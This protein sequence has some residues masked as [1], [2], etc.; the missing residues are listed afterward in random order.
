MTGVCVNALHSDTLQAHLHSQWLA[1]L[2]AVHNSLPLKPFHTCPRATF[3]V[4]V[5]LCLAS[6]FFYPADLCAQTPLPFDELGA[7]PRATAMGQAFTALADDTSAAYYNPAGLAQVQS[8]L[9]ITLGYQYAKPRIRVRFDKEPV[10]NPLLGKTRTNQVEDFSTKALYFGYSCNFGQV[11]AFKGSSIAE[12]IGIGIALFTNLPEVNQFDNPQRPQ[13]PYVFKYNERWSLISLAISCAVTCAPWLS[14]GG[15]V[16]PRVDSLQESTGSW[17]DLSGSA[18]PRDIAKGMRMNLNAT[19]KVNAVPIGGILITLPF[20]N[21]FKDKVSVG[22]SYRGKM[23]GFYGT[24]LTSVD[25][26]LPRPGRDPVV[27]YSDPGMRTIDYIGFNPEQITVGVALKSFYGFTAAFDMTWKKYS[28]FHFF[29]D[30]PPYDVID[31]VRVKNP[32]ND[33]WV[34]RVGL[35]YTFNPGLRGTYTRK[36]TEVSLLSGFYRE[37]SPVPD[38]NGPMNILDADQNVVSAGVGF[39]FDAEWAHYI[40]FEMFFQGHLFE[41]HYIRNHRDPLFSGITIGG[42]V[43]ACGMALTIAY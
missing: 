9:C 8:P 5:C 37:P 20:S 30:L 7:G 18:D 15:G 43:W 32:F 4:V 12:R 34:P 29:W 23:W 27:I 1:G 28:S 24:G 16:L 10:Q 33:V 11:S 41:E 3:A 26:L 22:V 25:I 14:V 35:G 6:C 13:D 40:K 19:T 42:Q 17:L 21:T 31:G 36:I 38:M 2:T 39:T